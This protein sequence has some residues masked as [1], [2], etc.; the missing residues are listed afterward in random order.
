MSSRPQEAQGI[1]TASPNYK[2]LKNIINN[3][4]VA[5]SSDR[6]EIAIVYRY[7]YP[8]VVNCEVSIY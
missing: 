2:L 5:V 3:A 6:Q 7:H 8:L 1:V 4:T